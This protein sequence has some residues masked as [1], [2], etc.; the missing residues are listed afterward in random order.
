LS[1]SVKADSIFSHFLTPIKEITLDCSDPKSQFGSYD[2][3]LYDP[4]N[5]IVCI[6]DDY[7]HPGVYVFDVHGKFMGKLGREGHGPAEYISPSDFCFS[8]DKRI[9]LIDRTQSKI[10]IY[11]YDGQF[12]KY[13]PLRIPKNGR[14]Y[15]IYPDA[16]SYEQQ[17]FFVFTRYNPTGDFLIHKFDSTGKYLGSFHRMTNRFQYGPEIASLNQIIGVTKRQI[18]FAKLFQPDIFLY[19]FGENLERVYTI[20]HTTATHS[21][22]IKQL[23]RTI[24]KAP[25][26][27]GFDFHTTRNELLHKLEHIEFLDLSDKYIFVKNPQKYMLFTR[28]GSCLY[29][30]DLKDYNADGGHRFP[31]DDPKVHFLLSGLYPRG[32]WEN[33]IIFCGFPPLEAR[34]LTPKIVVY[35]YQSGKK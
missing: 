23:D 7:Y 17:T 19:D 16:L 15:S 30:L 35:E 20:Q 33:G 32:R 18:Y 13:L 4:Q 6:L 14:K 31:P 3:I 24:A 11:R 25:N 29:Q 9:A 22:L 1:Y 27:K 28:D 2:K 34:S 5:K 26:K 21:R 8:S 10:L 12:L